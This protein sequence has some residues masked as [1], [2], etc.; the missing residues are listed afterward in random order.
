MDEFGRVVIPEAI[1][2]YLGWN[3][4]TKLESVDIN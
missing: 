2:E 4:G 1:R 3:K